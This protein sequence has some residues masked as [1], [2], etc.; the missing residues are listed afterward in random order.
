MVGWFEIPVNNMERAKAFYETVFNIE[1]NIVDF[2]GLLMG[3]FP[4]NNGAYGA[5]GTLIFQDSYVPSQEGTLV[6][7]ISENVQNELDRVE[8]SG[9]KIYKAKTKISE[10]HGHMG[11]FIDSE[12]N[13]VAL[14]SKA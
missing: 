11:V 9:G 12:G 2:G 10:E 6:Y 4:N 14:H 5:T 7:F 8:A 13:R 3:W 1:I